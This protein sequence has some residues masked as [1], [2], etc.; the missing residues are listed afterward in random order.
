MQSKDIARTDQQRNHI[1]Q[2]IPTHP[3]EVDATDEDKVAG[4]APLV[5]DAQHGST[6]SDTSEPTGP[7]NDHTGGPGLGLAPED[8]SDEMATTKRVR[9]TRADD[10]QDPPRH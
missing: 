8:Q 4:M 2:P 7:S 9:D 3:P 1:Q 10:L 6:R 5:H